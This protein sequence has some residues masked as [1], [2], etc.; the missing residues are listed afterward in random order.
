MIGGT[1]L[2]LG[3]SKLTYRFIAEMRKTDEEVT[4]GGSI[5]YCAQ[6]AWIQVRAS[7][8]FTLPTTN[9]NPTECHYP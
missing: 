7:F 8:T 3:F 5:A 4:F 9:N 6:T 2:R 1:V